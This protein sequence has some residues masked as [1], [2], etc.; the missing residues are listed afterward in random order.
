MQTYVEDVSL[1]GAKLVIVE[2]PVWAFDRFDSPAAP[3]EQP[4][5]D[6]SRSG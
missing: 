3:S 1:W 5:A 4:V 6:D 2:S